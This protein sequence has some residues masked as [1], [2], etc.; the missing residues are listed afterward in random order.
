MQAKPSETKRKAP[1]GIEVRHSRA[2][3]TNHGGA[4]CTCEPT[5]RP[6]VYDKRTGQKIRPPEPFSGKGALSA[7]KGWRADAL[8]AMG[9]GKSV[10]RSKRALREAAEAWLAGA[11]ADPPTV[12]TRSGYPF[13]PSAIRG[14]EADLKT[15]VLPTLGDYRLSEIRRG[16]VQALVDKLVG[17]GHSGSKIRNAI[18]PLRSVLRYAIRREE[19]DYNAT[20]DLELPNGIG[21]RQRA[22]TPAAFEAI[23]AP[24]DVDDRELWSVAFYAGLRRGEIRGLRWEDVT[25]NGDSPGGLIRVEQGWDDYAGP[26]APKSLAGVRTVPIP[27]LLA[28]RLRERMLRTGKRSGLVF[29]R[30]ASEAFTPSH[31][32]RR[33][34]KVW[35]AENEER[36]K[37]ELPPLEPIGL[38]EG[39]HSWK[40]WLRSAGVSRELRDEFGGHSDASVGRLYEHT[41]EQDRAEA[42]RIMDAYL[43]SQ[44]GAGTARRIEQLEE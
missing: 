20:A 7:A 25:L 19:I 15:F 36:A 27:T 3:A 34:A 41:S 38:H 13:K 10:A 44:L 9:K 43:A 14:Y 22:E 35:A 42:I 18:V 24:L 31:V 12:L 2:C 8:S 33:A 4:R 29:G 30:S 17:E 37:R 23:I 5:F 11:K 21:K 39:R 6:W 16:D 1:P 28:R 26:I 40:T 32:R